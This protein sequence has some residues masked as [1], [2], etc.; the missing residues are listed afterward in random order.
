MAHHYQDTIEK[1]DLK[2]VP[3]VEKPPHPFFEKN[4][5]TFLSMVKPL[6]SPNAQ[7]LVTFFLNFGE[8][9]SKDNIPDLGGLF[10]QL[11]SKMDP[12]GG[13][14]LLPALM[15]MLAGADNKGS[16]NPAILTTLMSMLATK[17][18]E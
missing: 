2:P 4:D 17:K 6:L 14:D 13:N 9:D 10:K 12:N 7:K 5:L 8:Q 16:L 11:T 1:T 15:S 3:S 18:E